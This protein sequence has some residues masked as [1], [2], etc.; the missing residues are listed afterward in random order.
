M[1]KTQPLLWGGGLQFEEE[2]ETHWQTQALKK[3]Y[4]YL[5][6]TLDQLNWNLWGVG[7]RSG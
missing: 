5:G 1:N 4:P 3:K 7:P 2:K 6:F